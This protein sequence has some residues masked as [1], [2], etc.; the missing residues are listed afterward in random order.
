[1]NVCM[2]LCTISPLLASKF[3]N[4]CMHARMY[5]CVC[6]YVCMYVCMHACMHL[7]HHHSLEARLCM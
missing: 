7:L 3:L 5:V 1:M 2:I 6:M 4:V